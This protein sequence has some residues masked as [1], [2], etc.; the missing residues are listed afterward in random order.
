MTRS[1]IRISNMTFRAKTAAV[2]GLMLAASAGA[3]MAQGGPGAFPEQSGK[4]IYEAIC[5]ACHMPDGKGSQG[6][7]SAPLG[8]PALA[9]N[10]KLVAP[11]Y[12]AF[13]VVRG[14]KAMPQ[15]GT[16]LS[17]TQVANVVN[18]IRTEFGNK[19]TNAITPDQVKAVR[20]ARADTGTDRPPG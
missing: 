13:V 7:G 14:Q 4:E 1:S 12:A 5:Q 11:A 8:Y 6:M 19:H 10:P 18:Y 16:S 20:P 9:G 3:A 2:A 15:F 17:D